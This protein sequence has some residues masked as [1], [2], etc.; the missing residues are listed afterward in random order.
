MDIGVNKLKLI[1]IIIFI[2]NSLLAFP[3]EKADSLKNL[4]K[5]VKPN[6]RPGILNELAF[7]YQTIDIDE[8]KSYAQQA[9]QL[10]KE[11]N[12][13]KQLSVAYSNLGDIYYF[14]GKQDTAIL[15]YKKSIKAKD[16]LNDTSG[17]ALI[18]NYAGIAYY[19]LGDYKSAFYHYN[20]SLEKYK[21][22]NNQQ[23][24]AG[25]LGNIGVLYKYWGET[26]TALVCYFKSL[27]ILNKI[28]N[29]SG[30]AGCCIN[31]GDIY[32]NQGK[33]EMAIEKYLEARTKYDSV[34][35]QYGVANASNIIGIVYYEWKNFDK[36][37]EYFNL[38]LDIN[39]EIDNKRGIVDA[40]SNIGLIY[41][42]SEEFDKAK[43]NFEEA[44]EISIEINKSKAISNCYNNLGRIYQHEKNY[45]KAIEYYKKSQEIEEKSGNKKGLAESLRNVGDI[46][47]EKS[48][49][50]NALYY[51]QK[52]LEISYN[53]S[54][55][56]IMMKNYQSIYKTYKSLGDY[57]NSL[58]NFEKFYYL[59]DSV[60]TAERHKQ[61][62]E[63]QTR[64]ETEKKEQRIK[65]QQSE[66][67]QKQATIN[68]ERIQKYAFSFVGLL[69]LI[70]AAVIYR[71]LKQKKKA[72]NLLRLQNVEILQQKEEITTQRD[73][74][75]T[76]RDQVTEQRDQIA[77]QKQKITDS[78]HYAS[79]IQN[80]VLPPD[81][82]MDQL[83]S[84]YF[85]LNIP[86][87]IVSGDFYWAVE[88][89]NKIIVCVADCTGHGVPGAFM[90]MLGVAFLNEI[91]NK[92]SWSNSAEI[93]NILREQVMSALHQTGKDKEAQDGMDIA[94]C[95][96]N[97]DKKTLDF[98]GA[99]SPLYLISKFKQKNNS[100]EENKVRIL[101]YDNKFLFELI[102]DN[103]PIG[104]H[105]N[106]DVVFHNQIIDY[107]DGD[108]LYL[109]SDGFIDQ[110]GEEKGKKFK[111][112]AF[113]ELL[114]N[115]QDKTMEEQRLII[116]EEF[117]N[118]MGN[119]KQIDDVCIIG[120]II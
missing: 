87:D 1:L 107:K 97:K 70:L 113:K 84:D 90:S 35:S 94:I 24:I 83:F 38:A 86:R 10:S 20:K 5:T 42:D 110:F 26:D 80:A 95:I 106:S 28:E 6:E 27:E 8:S 57:S 9:Y 18:H 47:F 76:Q 81:H 3:I 43:Q 36:A 14:T 33:Y 69:L 39:I 119:L 15:F 77:E 66:I 31:I 102:A 118:W 7:C 92:K 29:I 64:Y 117:Y 101:K 88:K 73:E 108:K 23:G 111:S 12:D 63:L 115:I 103:M 82:I 71:S 44:L 59:N 53:N 11:L 56:D 37:L 49:Y 55:A 61:F 91:V 85:I 25:A 2:T 100:V 112:K 48:D 116:K 93:L 45:D 104:I 51:Y 89:D 67:A 41:M 96:I 75:E 34:Q 46:Y 114:L 13:K 54:L 30:A 72:N 98:A 68:K 79:L 52:S 16:E 21:L 74:I 60:Y 17:S 62:N 105:V 65:L 58:I 50:N 22:T 19:D 99:N 32:K 120:A 40:K 109:F 78:I 4:L